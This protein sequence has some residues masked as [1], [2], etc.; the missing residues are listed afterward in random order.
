MDNTWRKILAVRVLGDGELI[1]LDVETID[2]RKMSF[3]LVPE[4]IA[5]LVSHLMDAKTLSHLAAAGSSTHADLLD[6]TRMRAPFA[7]EELILTDYVDRGRSLVQLPT[8][9]GGIFEF[10]VPIDRAVRRE[11]RG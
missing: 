3:R 7:A 10:L 6:P 4:M 1:E 5:L 8:P 9:S 11:A 2:G